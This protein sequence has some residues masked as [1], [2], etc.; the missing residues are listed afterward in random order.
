MVRTICINQVD[1]FFERVLFENPAPGAARPTAP[2]NRKSA[3]PMTQTKRAAYGTR[4]KR[5]H[6][7]DAG[8]VLVHV[9]SSQQT[10]LIFF[11]ENLKKFHF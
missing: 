3:G 5:L 4:I 11:H 10:Q 2:A 6:W 8:P 9:S 7:D 1:V